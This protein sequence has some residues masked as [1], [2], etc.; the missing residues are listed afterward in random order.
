[1]KINKIAK[2]MKKAKFKALEVYSGESLITASDILMHI[3]EE[4]TKEY[5]KDHTIQ[6]AEKFVQSMDME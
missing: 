6:Q 3:Q 1:M 2:V 5:L 4:L